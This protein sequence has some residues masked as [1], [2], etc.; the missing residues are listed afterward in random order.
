MLYLIEKIDEIGYEPLYSLL[1]SFG[2]WPVISPSWNET[3]FD[4]MAM[5][6][7]LTSVSSGSVM[8]IYVDIDDKDSTNHV[9]KV[10]SISIL[11]YGASCGTVLST[12]GAPIYYLG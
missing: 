11:D 9:L 4:L 10:N 12:S 2:G 8:S 7:N 6:I 1:N 5:L 3:D